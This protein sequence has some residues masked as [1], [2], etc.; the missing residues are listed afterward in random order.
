M[1]RLKTTFSLEGQGEIFFSSDAISSAV[2]YAVR[3]GK[4]RKLGARLYTK[5]MDGAPEEICRRNWAQIAAGY[6]PDSV[7]VGRTAIYFKPAEDGSV[8]LSATHNRQVKLPGLWLRAQ[9]GASP[10]ANDMPFMGNRVYMSS[11]ERAFLENVKPS[12][13]RAGATTRTLSRRE[14]EDAL[15]RYSSYD[16]A[17]LNR[18]RDNARELSKQLALED[19]YTELDKLIGTLLGTNDAKLVSRQAAAAARGIPFDQARI[20]AFEE[21][22]SR[23]LASG[24][25]ELKE[26]DDEDISTLAFFESY[27]SNYIEG[28]DFTVDQ[29]REIIFEGLVPQQRPQD[30]H[31]IVGT[32]RLVADPHERTRVPND[33]DHL[34]AILR[35]QHHQMLYERPE[36]GPGEWKRQNNHVGGRLFVDNRLVEGTL[37][38]SFRFYSSL[39]AGLARA[40]YC[41]FVVSE[42]HPFADGNGRTA[43]LLMNSELSAAGLQRIVITTR[44]RGDYMAALRGMTNNLNVEAFIAIIVDLQRRSAGVC[45]KSLQQARAQLETQGA[46]SEEPPPAGG[47]ALLLGS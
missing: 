26:N 37:R 10:H 20:D 4:A 19:E 34:I 18:L 11:R 13:A 22:A 33:A 31:D 3:A 39:P 1:P 27:F 47:A 6:F 41:L 8:F 42:V 12:R 7:I 16:E 35:S 15:Q 17:I 14:L 2:A 24:M 29:A 21:L 43:R 9:V 5:V 32:Y 45:F 46:F 36:I 23:L 38:E 28:T 40:T 25:P 44:D 30:A